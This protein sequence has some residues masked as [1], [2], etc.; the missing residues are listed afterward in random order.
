M[1]TVGVDRRR[2]D[3]AV[4]DVVLDEVVA[5]QLLLAPRQCEQEQRQAE[6][7]SE[8]DAKPALTATSS[9]EK[10]TAEKPETAPRARKTA[11]KSAAA[12]TSNGTANGAAKTTSSKKP[13]AP[14]KSATKANSGETPTR[15]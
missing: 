10:E 8:M 15:H 1:V 3:P 7:T 4:L 11:T 5:G 2:R 9:V 6:R 14:R 13:R 12:K